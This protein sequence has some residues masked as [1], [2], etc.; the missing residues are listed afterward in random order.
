MCVVEV[1]EVSLEGAGQSA[2]R[3]KRGGRADM[4]GE[5]LAA[6]IPG[7]RQRVTT[8]CAGECHRIAVRPV[9]R[10]SDGLVFLS[11]DELQPGMF[12]RQRPGARDRLLLRVDRA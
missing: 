7:E 8:E 6:R 4:N 10:T 11:E 5:I 3:Q 9:E 1:D 2:I 12:D